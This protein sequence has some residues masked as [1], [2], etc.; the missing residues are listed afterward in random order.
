MQIHL[1]SWSD[2]KRRS[3]RPTCITVYGTVTIMVTRNLTWLHVLPAAT[4]VAACSSTTDG[5]GVVPNGGT[6]AQGASG[7][8]GAA[9]SGAGGPINLGGAD[10][11][12]G[13][14]GGSLGD[15]ACAASQYDGEH[16]PL[17]MHIV[18]DR[19]GSMKNQTGS[20]KSLWDATEQAFLT[21]MNAPQ[22]VGTGVGLLLFPPVS[23]ATSSCFG[24][25]G[26]NCPPGCVD[27]FGFCAPDENLLCSISDFSPPSVLI[28]P[29]PAVQAKIASALKATSPGGGTPT[30]P[31]MAA[32]AQYAASHAS[33]HPDRQVI[34]VLATDGNPNNCNSTI[35]N[36]A[37]VAAAAAAGSPSVKTFVIG[38][39][40]SGV[41]VGGLHQIAKA[42]GTSSA[43][44]VNPTNAGKEFLAAIQ[45]IQGQAL[46]CT[47]KVPTPPPG[48]TFDPLRV[49]VV[50]TPQAG[51][52]ELIFN[53]DG[54]AL[55]NPTQGGWYYDDPQNP[56]EISLCPET[57]KHVGGSTGKVRIEL[58][59]D[60]VTVPR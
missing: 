55:C 18:F 25:T 42:G 23:T 5:S 26:P 50:H 17:D 21:F 30:H 39:N 11:G 59:C 10:A 38:I 37:N 33:T 15:A 13:A 24:H 2:E 8:A 9:G 43:L 35:Q 34:L 3:A 4:I 52:P 1:G 51:A 31:A 22:S 32:A 19:S 46:G 7:S 48:E 12:T 29:L 27:V 28:E 54:P 56:T 47:F 20:G 60:T 14:S 45:A 44:I 49:N 36:V 41:N 6:G 58:G 40:N 16:V 57:C 53:V